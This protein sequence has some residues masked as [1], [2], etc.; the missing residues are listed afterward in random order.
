MHDPRF[1]SPEAQERYLAFYDE[2]GRHWPAPS[3]NRVLQ[4]TFGETFV[5]VNGPADGEPLILLP[6]LSATSLMWI[7]YIAPWSRHYRT[8]ALD[9]PGDAGRSVPLKRMAG[10]E[11]NVRWLDEVLNGL[12][13]NRTRL[14]GMSYGG[15]LAG[16]YAVHAPSRLHK[17][18]LIAP[19]ATVLPIRKA[20]LAR[21]VMTFVLGFGTMRRFWYWN[22]PDLAR[23]HPAAIDDV[24]KTKILEKQCLKLPLPQRP[25]CL[26][27]AELRSLK[28]PVLFLVGEND[29]LYSAHK[30]VERLRRISPDIQTQI[31]GGAGHDVLRLH[32]EKVSAMVLDFLS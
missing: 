32:V 29:K 28:M 27:D 1:R 17:V 9:I 6:G 13:L 31:I 2:R 8:Y 20:F 5:R 16:Q 12:Q 14:V 22:L 18:V 3:E 26:S 15:W 30:A 19:A 10:A 11:H 7:Q 25:T 4:T 23:T 21:S 24:V